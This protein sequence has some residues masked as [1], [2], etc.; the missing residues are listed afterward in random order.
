MLPCTIMQFGKIRQKQ[1]ADDKRI[2]QKILNVCSVNCNRNAFRIQ[3]KYSHRTKNTRMECLILCLLPFA[4]NHGI[5]FYIFS[6]YLLFRFC[7]SNNE[8]PHVVNLC[9]F[10]ST[11]IQLV[12]LLFAK[13]FF[14]FVS[15][16]ET[17]ILKKIFLLRHYSFRIVIVIFIGAEWFA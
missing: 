10:H 4:F 7:F 17:L 8:L 1:Y 16:K 13:F 5:F 14:P 6:F 11:A 12:E 9:H 15:L 2:D 3:N